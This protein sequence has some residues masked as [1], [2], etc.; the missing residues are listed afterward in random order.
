VALGS[1]AA[2][3]AGPNIVLAA[4]DEARGQSGPL[5]QRQVESSSGFRT[6]SAMG[7]TFAVAYAQTSRD[8]DWLHAALTSRYPALAGSRSTPR[9]GEEEELASLLAAHGYVTA[10]FSSGPG[11]DA[12]AVASTRSSATATGPLGGHRDTGLAGLFGW[13]ERPRAGPFF[14]MVRVAGGSGGDLLESLMEGLRRR[15][16]ESSTMVLAVVR[17][18]PAGRSPASPGN[19]PDLERLL[20]C[21]LVVAGPGV[22]RGRR[23]RQVVE[24]LDLA[25]TVLSSCSIPPYHAHQGRSLAGYLEAAEIRNADPDRVAFGQSG[26][27]FAARTMGWLLSGGPGR[28]SELFELADDG[29]P[30]REVSELNPEVTRR[31]ESRLYDWLELSLGRVARPGPRLNAVER[32]L[33]RRGGYW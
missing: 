19:A 17:G 8:P 26:T 1:P 10:T 15:R 31:L 20:R 27:L 23:V 2:W 14:A 24:L 21:S 28:R 30:D 25:P 16:L 5:G 12:P 11:S 33:F 7:T 6:L 29:D 9:A 32:E 18:A 13:L 4:V 22:A 3:A